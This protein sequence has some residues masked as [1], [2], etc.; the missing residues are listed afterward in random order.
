MLS[1][2]LIQVSEEAQVRR[3]EKKEGKGKMA[4]R[5]FFCPRE[6]ERAI[7][8]QWSG[9]LTLPQVLSPTLLRQITLILF[10]SPQSLGL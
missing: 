10:C 4:Q 8:F 3:K 1:I 7:Q 2:E 5:G 9:E 6:L